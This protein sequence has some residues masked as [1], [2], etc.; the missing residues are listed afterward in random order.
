MYLGFFHL[1]IAKKIKIILP[2]V[3]FQNYL[4]SIKICSFYL[5]RL[6]Y[7]LYT[8]INLCHLTR[9]GKN[10][11]DHENRWA[12]WLFTWWKSIFS[13]FKNSSLIVSCFLC[14]FST[15]TKHT[16]ITCIYQLAR[17]FSFCTLIMVIKYLYKYTSMQVFTSWIMQFFHWQDT[18]TLI[19][20]AT[21]ILF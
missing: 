9:E 18:V 5:H 14:S 21:Y 3:L 10:Y 20:S 19:I 15:Q 6:R 16:L 8:G 12:F 2:V 4:K 1:Y 13:L 7:N 17:L 11:L